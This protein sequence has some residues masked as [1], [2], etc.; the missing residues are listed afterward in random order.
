MVFR[1]LSQKSLLTVGAKR[2]SDI[3]ERVQKMKFTS[4]FNAVALALMV[5]L[6][7]RSAKAG[8]VTFTFTGTGLNGSTAAGNF[9]VDEGSLYP[10]YFATGG[11]FPSLALTI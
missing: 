3:H 5:C 10:G 2:T 11:V 4:R 1:R 6:F 8:F 7:C 9:T